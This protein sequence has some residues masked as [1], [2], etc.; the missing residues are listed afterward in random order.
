MRWTGNHMRVQFTKSRACENQG[1]RKSSWKDCNSSKD[2]A[3]VK[4]LVNDKSNRTRWSVRSGSDETRQDN[5]LSNRNHRRPLQL[6]VHHA[7]TRASLLSKRRPCPPSIHALAEV[8]MSVSPTAMRPHFAPELSGR[9]SAWT[10]KRT[11]S[12]SEATS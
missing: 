8:E 3:Q 9:I 1:L 6:T 5:I 2:A 4:L 7:H 11:I 10:Q 12:N